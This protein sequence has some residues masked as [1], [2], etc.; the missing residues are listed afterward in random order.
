MQIAFLNSYAY[1]IKK[2]LE[3]GEWASDIISNLKEKSRKIRKD[4]QFPN[5]S[6]QKGK[7]MEPA[8]YLKSR[9]D[10]QIDWYDTKNQQNQKKFKILKYK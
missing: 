3:T 4:D 8:E 2:Y 1:K 5:F 6:I 10:N 7:Q 9:L